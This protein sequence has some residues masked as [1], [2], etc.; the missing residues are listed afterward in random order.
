[1]AGRPAHVD[2]G[3][4]AT[5]E[6]MGT[7]KANGGRGVRH[8]DRSRPFELRNR[9]AHQYVSTGF[10]SLGIAKPF[11]WAPFSCLAI[12]ESTSESDQDSPYFLDIFFTI[13]NGI[14]HRKKASEPCSDI[15]PFL[16]SRT[17]LPTRC[18]THQIH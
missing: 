16:H 18:W 8:S 15:N 6:A 3:A 10:Y 12:A 5:L 13:F 11:R 2:G 1:M 7:I 17:S 4:W 9:C 14:N